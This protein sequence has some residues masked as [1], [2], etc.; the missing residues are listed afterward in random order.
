MPEI[1]AIQNQQH[2]GLGRLGHARVILA[3]SAATSFWDRA[4]RTRAGVPNRT[5]ALVWIKL[6]VIAVLGG[7]A[8][9]VLSRNRGAV[10]RAVVQGVPIVVPIVLVIL[11]LGTFVLDRTRFGRYIYA[12]GGNAEAARRA[13]VKVMLDPLDRLHRVLEPRRLAGLFSIEQGRRGRRGSGR[14]IVLW[15]SPPLSSVA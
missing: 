8:V 15:V 11:W 12:I 4:R 3:V 5:I 13:G 2:A 1:T 6:G 7:A 14:E 9:C 10:G